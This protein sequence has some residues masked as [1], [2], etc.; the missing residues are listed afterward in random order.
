MLKAIDTEGG[1][2]LVPDI[3]LSITDLENSIQTFS[4]NSYNQGSG[5]VYGS[6]DVYLPGAD[7]AL[8]HLAGWISSRAVE[9]ADWA[10]PGIN[11]GTAIRD[12]LGLKSLQDILLAVRDMMVPSGSSTL[13]QVQN[14]KELDPELLVTIRDKAGIDAQRY[15]SRT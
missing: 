7:G 2:T 5:D 15:P 1:E 12:F 3:S 11:L 4:P 6:I 8:G 10:T 9:V 13:A 14:Y